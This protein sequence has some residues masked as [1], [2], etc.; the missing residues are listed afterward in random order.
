MHPYSVRE[1]EGGGAEER[2]IRN[3]M[4]CGIITSATY[5][6]INGLASDGGTSWRLLSRRIHLPAPTIVP[7]LFAGDPRAPR[8]LA[9]MAVVGS[10]REELL[11]LLKLVLSIE[12]Q[13]VDPP[14]EIV[15][16]R[17]DLRVR[18][19]DVSAVRLGNGSPAVAVGMVLDGRLRVIGED[20][21]LS[22][23]TDGHSLEAI[24]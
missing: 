18:H 20:D 4:V 23:V 21:F 13:G 22:G 12:C 24:G 1:R 5:G 7:V 14:A 16:I 10:A 11:V 17:S 19:V 8:R 6:S 2:T 3:I 15:G 9:S